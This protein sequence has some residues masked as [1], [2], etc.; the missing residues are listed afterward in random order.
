MN[1]KEAHRIIGK[2]HTTFMLKRQID[3]LSRLQWFNTY[4]DTQRLEAAK[5]ILKHMKVDKT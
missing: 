2:N 1:L 5:T 4:E 3:A